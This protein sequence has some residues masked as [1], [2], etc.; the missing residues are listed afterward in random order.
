M[1]YM[2]LDVSPKSVCLHK[3]YALNIVTLLLA[4]IPNAR[5]EKRKTNLCYDSNGNYF[6]SL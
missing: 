6:L 3:P 1:N 4:Y 2:Q 5:F